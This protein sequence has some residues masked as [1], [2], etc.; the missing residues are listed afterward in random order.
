MV[1]TDICVIGAGP[2]GLSPLVLLG[3]GMQLFSRNID[4]PG[5]LS[6]V[7]D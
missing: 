4:N 5:S 7:V 6:I 3:T 2:A 1:E